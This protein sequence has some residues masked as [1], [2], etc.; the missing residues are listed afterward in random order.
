M[1][2]GGSGGGKLG[3]QLSLLLQPLDLR[4]QVLDLLG[5]LVVLLHGFRGH[6][7]VLAAVLLQERFGLLPEGVALAAQFQNLAHNRLP[8]QIHEFRV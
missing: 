7:A 8:P 4:A 6:K 3:I 5:H 2:R 1:D